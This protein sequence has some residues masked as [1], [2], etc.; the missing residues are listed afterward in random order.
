MRFKLLLFLLIP[1]FVWAQNKP[2]FEIGL[3]LDNDSFAS[4]YN[5]FYYTNG[6]FVLAN[7]L[8]GKST[9]EKKIVHGFKIGQQIYNPRD[10]KSVFPEDHNRPYAGYLFAEYN[11]TKMYQSNRVFGMS[12]SVGVVGPNSKAEEFQDWMHRAFDFGDIIGWEYQI[13]NLVAVQLGANYSQPVFSK[14]AS[15]KIDFNLYA[16]ADVGTAFTGINV[17]AL[18]RMSFLES[19]TAMQNSN[20]YNGFGSSKQEFYFF[21]VPKINVQLYDATIQ[22]SLFNDNSSVTFDLKPFRFK[23]QAGLK[24][25]YSHI[26]LSCIFNYTSD[27]IKSNSATGY[28]FGS[29]GASYAF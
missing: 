11:L 12:I 9:V 13:Q 5:D 29:L 21:M 23:A 18:I 3:Q 17:G 28:Y 7:Y 20:F 10:V 26:N 2:N 14:T 1:A 8:S 6:I 15:D 25:K 19:N 4:T 24:Y 27:E 22:G 16:D